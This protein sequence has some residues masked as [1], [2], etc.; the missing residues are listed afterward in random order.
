MAPA[1]RRWYWP[2]R[3]LLMYGGLALASIIGAIVAAATP[4]EWTVGKLVVITV[5]PLAFTA[6]C[7]M[8][9][10]LRVMGIPHFTSLGIGHWVPRKL[11]HGPTRKKMEV[12]LQ[13]VTS[14]FAELLPEEARAQGFDHRVQEDS[15]LNRLRWVRCTW[16]CQRINW[17]S[18][19]GWEVRD[20]AGLQSGRSIVVQWRGSTLNSAYIHELGHLLRQQLL[21]LPVDYAHQDRRWWTAVADTQLR[22]GAALKELVEPGNSGGR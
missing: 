5:V 21:G 4:Q 17:I 16:T 18:R 8:V 9:L 2:W 11:R 3:D 22:V 12:E 13:R 6:I 19:W 1:G 7:V 15:I 10:A 14:L 20:K